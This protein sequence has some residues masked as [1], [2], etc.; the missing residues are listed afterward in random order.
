MGFLSCVRHDDSPAHALHG[1][2]PLLEKIAAFAAFARREPAE[3]DQGLMIKVRAVLCMG[4]EGVWAER[5]T[6]PT[7]ASLSNKFIGGALMMNGHVEWMKSTRAYTFT[8]EDGGTVWNEGQLREHYHNYLA[9]KGYC[10]APRRC[11]GL[12]YALPG[13]TL[14]FGWG[15][16]VTDWETASQDEL[17]DRGYLHG[18][19]LLSQY[20]Q[21]AREDPSQ[22]DGGND[23]EGDE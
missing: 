1:M 21:F 2:A 6:N 8:N 14:V 19:G 17:G 10:G 18:G 12:C 22:L 9:E 23:D 11:R 4:T 3:D 20:C 16:Q 15:G 7:A 5:L 13:D